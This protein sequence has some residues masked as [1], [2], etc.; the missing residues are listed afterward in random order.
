VYRSICEQGFIPIFATDDFDPKPYVS[1]C[2]QAGCRVIEYT[3][4]RSDAGETIQWIR[5]TYP[6]LFLLVGSTL[7]QDWI[8][9]RLKKKQ[10]H[11][12]TLDELA[13]LDID[14][15]VSMMGWSQD[16]IRKYAPTHILAP[17]AM[18]LREAFQQ[19]AAGASFIKIIGTQ[20]D[21]VRLLQGDGAFGF[22]PIL[23]T[24][25]MTRERIPETID[26]GAL[27]VASGLEVLAQGCPGD[28]EPGEIQKEVERFLDITQKAQRSRWPWVEEGLNADP[29]AWIEKVPHV[30]LF[31]D[32]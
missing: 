4:R 26:A 28:K 20:I 14:G 3:L 17:T 22:C 24:G 11:L 21:F 18:T 19:M 32:P 6:D 27:V 16:S 8:V 30:H 10:P 9:S 5:N 1:A 29:E 2:V 13:A 12:L 7:D 25:G 15:M 31:L 23:V